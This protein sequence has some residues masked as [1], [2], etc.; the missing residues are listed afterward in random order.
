MSTAVTPIPEQTAGLSQI[1]RITNV[2]VAPSKTFN[3]LNRSSNWIFAYLV[4]VVCSLA[5]TSTVG[6]KIGFEKV[7][8]N[9]MRF[10]PAAR[11]AQIEALPPDQRA[12][13]ERQGVTVTKA[14]S[15]GFSVLSLIWL[16]IVALVLWGTFSFGLGAEVGYA[17]SLAIVVFASL[18]G[19][20]K[21]LLGVAV[22]LAGMDPDLFM[23]QNPVGTNPGYYLNFAD[24][25]RF[26]Y[27]VASA[28]DIFTIWT[29]VL[30]AIGFTC[31]AKVKKGTAMA[32]IFALWAFVTLCGAA[33][34][35]A[36]S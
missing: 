6:A 21:V 1:Q 29:L 18:P 12:K 15:Y 31:V 8:Q 28:L 24:T 9:Q 34:G 2:F 20:F 10:A 17:K 11:Q 35:A 26:L 4:M 33:L 14:I 16:A 36:F 27:S 22:I 3:D 32:V 5:Y 30:T 13:A 19:I 23:I 7:S 25:P